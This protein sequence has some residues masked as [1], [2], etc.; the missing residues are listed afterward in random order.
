MQ[1]ASTSHL[2]RPRGFRKNAGDLGICA[3]NKHLGTS[4]LCGYAGV[5]MIQVPSAP[6]VEGGRGIRDEEMYV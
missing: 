5:C 6:A 2:L 4:K 3:Q 1:L